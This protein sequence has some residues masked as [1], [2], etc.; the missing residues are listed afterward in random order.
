MKYEA[1]PSHTTDE[2]HVGSRWFD[3]RYEAE[4]YARQMNEED[5]RNERARQSSSSSSYSGGSSGGSS[6]RS[7]PFSGNIFEDT[8]YS[9]ALKPMLHGMEAV[10]RWS[11]AIDEA[12]SPE[13]KARAARAQAAFDAKRYD[14]AYRLA[15]EA[16]TT[17]TGIAAA[18]TIVG[19]CYLQGTGVAQDQAKAVEWFLKAHK[20]GD[21]EGGL[22]L[23]ACYHMGRGTPKNDLQALFCFQTAG[24]K[25]NMGAQHNAGECYFQGWGT[26]R[27]FVKAAM[28]YKKAA[29][30]GDE[31]AQKQVEK[32]RA[33]GYKV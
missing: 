32:I 27:D 24:A 28:W 17:G 8:E 14:E 7:Q 12:N 1:Q 5:E 13:N 16:A 18:K 2:W 4:A 3:N 10:E 25:G 22:S 19:K 26:E 30:Q 31:Y 9:R 6:P 11:K 29:A 15:L 23:G 20:G 21:A 33:A